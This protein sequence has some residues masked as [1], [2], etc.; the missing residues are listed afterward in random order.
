VRVRFDNLYGKPRSIG[1]ALTRQSID[2]SDG[3][4]AAIQLVTDTCLPK[5]GKDVIEQAQ[6]SNV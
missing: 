4:A 1:E 2:T 6:R 3:Q 5:P